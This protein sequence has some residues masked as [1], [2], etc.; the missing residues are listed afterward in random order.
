MGKLLVALGGLAILIGGVWFLQGMGILLGSPMSGQSF[1][2]Y[3]GGGVLVVGVIALWFG[4]RRIE[5]TES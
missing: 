2:A 3:A 1:W 5:H 4:L